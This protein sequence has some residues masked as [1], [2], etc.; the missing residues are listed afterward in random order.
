MNAKAMSTRM[1]MSEMVVAGL[2]V[3]MLVAGFATGVFA[4]P[5]QNPQHGPFVS[6]HVISVASLDRDQDRD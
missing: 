6:A 1:S 2:A 4:R 3:A 5:A